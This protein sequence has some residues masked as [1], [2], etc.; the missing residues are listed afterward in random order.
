MEIT[1]LNASVDRVHFEKSDNL[2]PRK[3][4]SSSVSHHSYRSLRTPTHLRHLQASP[5]SCTAGSWFQSQSDVM[6]SS[7]LLPIRV[8]GVKAK[9]SS[10]SERSVKDNLKI[11][12]GCRSVW[13]LCLTSFCF[14][15]G[16]GMNAVHFP[17]FAEQQGVAREGVSQF[18]TALGLVIMVAR[19]AGGFLLNGFQSTPPLSMVLV[20]LQMAMGLILALAP[21]Y[22]TG[23]HGLYAMQVGIA[24]TYGLGYMLFAPICVQMLGVDL[25]AISFGLVQL[26]IG[27][28]YILS[29]IIAGYLYDA[30]GTFEL[31]LI[32]GGSIISLGALPLA[33]VACVASC[34]APPGDTTEQ[35][36]TGRQLEGPG[37][38]E[39]ETVQT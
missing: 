32:L 13:M 26:F 27:M 20:I 31:P 39:K 19:L 16:Y 2:V 8:E 1:S 25:L 17:S 37:I 30:T 18:Y 35:R 14:I 21:F 3:R 28:G 12:L 5:R 7:L 10:E 38:L 36:G 4:S 33:L 24:L 15:F 6:G 11:V 23:I 29:P 22:A 34:N 9:A